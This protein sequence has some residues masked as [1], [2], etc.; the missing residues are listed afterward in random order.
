MIIYAAHRILI[1]VT[2]ILLYLLYQRHVR[3]I[4]QLSADQTFFITIIR[5][6]I[7]EETFSIVLLRNVN[8]HNKTTDDLYSLIKEISQILFEQLLHISLQIFI[9][10]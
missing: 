8:L 5:E 2:N 1:F 4:L 9:P 10:E 7:E 3:S 6:N